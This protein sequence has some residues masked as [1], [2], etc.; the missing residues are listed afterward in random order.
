[1]TPSFLIAGLYSH[2]LIRSVWF[3]PLLHYWDPPLRGHLLVMKDLRLHSAMPFCM[4]LSPSETIFCDHPLSL[5]A[6]S[7]TSSSLLIVCVQ[8]EWFPHSRVIVQAKHIS[9]LQV[10]G[11]QWFK[12]PFPQRSWLGVFIPSHESDLLTCGI[13]GER[14]LGPWICPV[15]GPVVG[16]GTNNLNKNL[17]FH[18]KHITTR[19]QTFV[20]GQVQWSF[21]DIR[22]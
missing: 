1:M 4:V 12:S 8:K 6:C 15:P 3:V 17:K 21:D 10:E 16:H 7:F 22:G 20:H 9:L 11:L 5:V 19:K 13:L 2:P 14:T 18:S